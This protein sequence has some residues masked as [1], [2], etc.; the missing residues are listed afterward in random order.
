MDGS[1]AIDGEVRTDDIDLNGTWHLADCRKIYADGRSRRPWGGSASG[2]LLYAPDGH[3]CITLNFPGGD[4]LV[5]CNSYCGRYEIVDDRVIHT[6]SVSADVEQIGTVRE[7]T[8]LYTPELLTLTMSP[9]AGAGPG[10]SMEYVWRR[11][12]A[13]GGGHGSTHRAPGENSFYRRP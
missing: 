13:K 12:H 6:V 10:S 11:A 1:E 9:A 8:I 7:A 2:F 5:R 4:G 3:V